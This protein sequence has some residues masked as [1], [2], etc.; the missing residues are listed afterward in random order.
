MELYLVHIVFI[1]VMSTVSYLWGEWDG[2]KKG[3]QNVIIDFIDRKL[4]TEEQLRKEYI[5]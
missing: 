3:Q 2:M 1:C 4:I 5:D